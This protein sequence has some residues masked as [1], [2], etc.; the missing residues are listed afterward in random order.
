M[1]ELPARPCRPPIITAAR[2]GRRLGSRLVVDVAGRQPGG[3]RPAQPPQPHPDQHR[4]DQPLAPGGEAL[5]REDPAQGERDQPHDP[6]PQAVAD[7][8]EEPHPPAAAPLVDHQR[9]HRREV[10]RSREGVD[11]AG[12]Q[13]GEAG[14]EDRNVHEAET[15][16]F[17]TLSSIA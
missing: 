9:R 7:P 8:P 12:G 14:D 4:P 6:D 17:D 16:P 11:E 3:E 5:D 13:S 2:P 10:V 15:L 1:C